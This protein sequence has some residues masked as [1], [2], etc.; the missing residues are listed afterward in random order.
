MRARK[1]GIRDFGLTD[2]L[3][4]C[5]TLPDIAASRD[6][7]LANEASPHF[8]F[9]VEASCMSQW[10]LDQIATGNYGQPV[11]GLRS[12]GPAGGTLAV[13]LTAQDIQD[14]GIEYV[15]GGVHWPMYVPLEPQALIRDYHRQNMFLASHPLVDI[16]AHPWWWH[17]QWQDADGV[18][19]SD[20]WFDDFAKIPLAM[21]EEFAVVMREHGKVVEINLQAMLLNHQYPDSFKRQYLNYLA[22]LKEQGVKL[23]TG[24]DC[25]DAHY[26]IDF[27]RAA[28]MLDSVG[29]RD[30]ELW[31][32][33]PRYTW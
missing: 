10:E 23:C 33:P 29:I 21:H 17:G 13:V 20:P 22:G 26:T 12:G 1:N 30:E 16:V 28:A 4:T 31:R 11:Y 9:G 14:Y 27:E 2:H 25:H 7:F 18:Y 6:E 19:R 32:L 8:H 24:S 5:H 3:H 15:V